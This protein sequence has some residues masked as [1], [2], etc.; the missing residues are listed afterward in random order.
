[1]RTPLAAQALLLWILAG[2]IQPANAQS[3][4]L[5]DQLVG[6]WTLVSLRASRPDGSTDEP[7]GSDGKGTL[8][9]D[10]NGGFALILL[11]GSLPKVTSGNREKPSPEEAMA[12]A[13]GTFCFYGTYTVDVAD[14]SFVFNVEASNFQNFNGTKQK[15]LVKNISATELRFI[16]VAPPSGGTVTEL[17]YRR[18]PA[19]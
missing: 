18:D 13:K 19:K 10:R 4:G 6:S 14:Q 15:R 8:I 3:T 7:Y 16:N 1:M 9:F 11:N 12:I 17:V 5:K 2:L